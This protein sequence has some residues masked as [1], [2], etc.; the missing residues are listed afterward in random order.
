MNYAE[1]LL[2]QLIKFRTVSYDYSRK[3][4]DSVEL[5]DFLRNELEMLGFR[6]SIRS[7]REDIPVLCGDLNLEKEKTMLFVTHYDVVPPGS[8]W[9][10]DPFVPL[11]RHGRIYGRGASDDKGGIAAFISAVKTIVDHGKDTAFNIRFVCF[12]DEELGGMYGVDYMLKKHRSLLTCDAAYI[13]DGS[14]SAIGV[15][16]SS[17]VSGRIDVYGK[18]GHSAYPFK[19]EN[20]LEL[21]IGLL[22]RLLEFKRNEEKRVSKLFRAIP[23][24]VSRNIWNRFSVTMMHSGE[25]PNM[26][27]GKAELIFNWRL[28]PEENVGERMDEFAELFGKW[29]EELEIKAELIFIDSIPGYAIK[30]HDPFVKKLSSVVESIC[31]FKPELCVELGTT[32]GARIFRGL[33][34]PTFAFGP[35]DEDAGIHSCNEFIRLSTL[36]RVKHVIEKFLME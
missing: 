6:T 35:S 19:C 36:E 27:P 16:C 30:G 4:Q 9:E 28:M 29:K 14:T 7:K 21:A 18:E 32:D 2:E 26:I 11:K 33:N 5:V 8:G 22:S 34:V 3:I 10:T 25:K 23:N 20:A 31:N 15:G 17:Y 12:G 13:L 1:K 24:P